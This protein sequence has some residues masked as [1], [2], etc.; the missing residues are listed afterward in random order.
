MTKHDIKIMGQEYFTCIL[1]FYCFLQKS[2]WITHTHTLET[3]SV[4]QMGTWRPHDPG[5]PSMIPT[6][7]WGG[8]YHRGWAFEHF[9]GKGIASCRVGSGFLRDLLCDGQMPVRTGVMELPPT[10]LPNTY[11]VHVVYGNK[12]KQPIYVYI[13]VYIYLYIYMKKVQFC[14]SF[15]RC[16]V[17]LRQLWDSGLGDGDAVIHRW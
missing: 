2:G 6:D 8:E 1:L 12:W 16:C 17:V 3:R 10:K 5:H 14:L 9:I 7:L 15:L 11:D 4:Q 13:H